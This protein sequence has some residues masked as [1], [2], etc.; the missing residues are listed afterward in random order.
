MGLDGYVGGFETQQRAR[1]LQEERDER[2]REFEVRKQQ[3]Q[4]RDDG[5]LA[6]VGEAS[7]TDRRLWSGSEARPPWRRRKRLPTS[8]SVC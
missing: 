1:R 2:A 6:G 4:Q 5:V 7:T 3:Q 8:P